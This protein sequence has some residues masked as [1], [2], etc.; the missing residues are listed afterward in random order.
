MYRGRRTK[1][2]DIFRRVPR[3]WALICFSVL[4]GLPKLRSET[5]PHN[6]LS[7]FFPYPFEYRTSTQSTSSCRVQ[8][9]LMLNIGIVVP[10][11]KLI[12]ACS[13]NILQI[14]HY[15]T[16][17]LLICFLAGMNSCSC[18]S[19][20]RPPNESSRCDVRTAGITL[21]LPLRWGVVRKPALWTAL[22][23]IYVQYIYS[24]MKNSKLFR[25][26]IRQDFLLGG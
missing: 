7:Y 11:F 17:M 14:I 9:L 10:L 22:Q 20:G 19:G 3:S 8:C 13:I 24:S 4:F 18:S 26:K 15:I 12:I 5:F 23:L 1:V 6:L 21:S 25:L 16:Y 2:G